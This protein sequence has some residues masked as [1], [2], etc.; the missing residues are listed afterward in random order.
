[1]KFVHFLCKKTEKALKAYHGKDQKQLVECLQMLGST[2]Q[3]GCSLKG[4]AKARR[5]LGKLMVGMLGDE[6]VV[7]NCQAKWQLALPSN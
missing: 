1:M 2:E 3:D 5:T 6:A 4:A 7:R